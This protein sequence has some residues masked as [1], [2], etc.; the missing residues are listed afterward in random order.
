[1][2]SARSSLKPVESD[3]ERDP[4]RKR[5]R[6]DEGDPGIEAPLELTLRRDQ[7][8]DASDPKEHPPPADERSERDAGDQRDRE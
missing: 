6:G 8:R 3:P 4:D 5:D 1:M 7:Y 2:A